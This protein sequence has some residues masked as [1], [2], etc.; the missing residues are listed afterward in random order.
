MSLSVISER[1]AVS[2]STPMKTKQIIAALENP[3]HDFP[4]KISYTLK[5]DG[6]LVAAIEGTKGGKARRVEFPYPPAK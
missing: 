3:Q 6:S 2:G 5:G 4:Q 1:G